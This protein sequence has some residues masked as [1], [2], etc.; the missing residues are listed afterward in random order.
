MWSCPSSC[1]NGSLRKAWTFVDIGT[2]D[3]TVS[4]ALY[5]DLD[6]AEQKKLAFRLGDLAVEIPPLELVKSD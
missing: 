1:P 5:R 2:P 3:P 4:S 6:L